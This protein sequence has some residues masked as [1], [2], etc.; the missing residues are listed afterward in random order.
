MKYILFLFVI[1]LSFLNSN[2]QNL[3]IGQWREHLPYNKGKQVVDAGT[4]IYC[5]TDE[6]LFAFVKED[7]SIER[8]T[9]LNGLNDFGISTIAYHPEFN[10]LIIAYNNANIDLMYNDRSVFNLPFIKDKDITG[11]K[12]INN[13]YIKGKLAYLSCGFGIVVLDIERQEVKDTYFIGNNGSNRNVLDITDDGNYI[14]AATDSGL[15][16]ALLSSPNLADYNYW[17]VILADTGN[18]G[19]FNMLT[20]FNGKVYLNYAKPNASTT[21]SDELWVLD[22]TQ[23]S[24]I[25]LP[26]IPQQPKR[27]RIKVQNNALV[28]INDVSV[29]VFDQQLHRIGFYDNSLYVNAQMRDAVIE[30]N[31]IVWIA[32]HVKGLIKIENNTLSSIITPG[33]PFSSFVGQI[34]IKDGR[35][36]VAHGPKSTSWNPQDYPVDGFSLLKDDSWKTWNNNNTP[37]LNSNKF[38]SNMSID[39][40]PGQPEHIRIGSVTS[41]VLDYSDNSFTYYKTSNSTLDS[42]FGNPTQTIVHGIVH[43]DLGNLWVVNSGVKNILHVQYRER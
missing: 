8:F 11:L 42:A 22:S 19:D 21:S 17:N 25:N 23:W 37:S 35:V 12:N 29:S 34:A 9:K 31:G 40:V 16:S 39:I 26:E 15:F 4:K 14:Y 10:V 24:K 2:A 18:A 36:W 38:F 1:S 13:I 27:Y 7:A 33:G 41:G 28:I 32:D 43:D 20:T 30:S 5:A 6:G 3:S